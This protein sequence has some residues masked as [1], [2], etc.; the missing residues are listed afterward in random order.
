MSEFEFSIPVIV[1]GGGACGAVAAL[2]AH[3]AGAQVIVIERDA[4]PMGTSA[5]SQGVFC[6]A[7]TRFQKEAGVEDSA[8]IF[9][10]DIMEKSRGLAD[11]AI[12]R[13]IAEE[14]APT[15]EW[16][17]DRHDFPWKLNSQFRA[18]YGNSRDR[19][20]G[21]EGHAGED[22]VQWFHRRLG[23][24]GIDVLCETRLIDVVPGEDGGIAGVKLQGGDG[25]ITTIGCRALVMACGGFGANR[26]MTDRYMPETRGFRYNG[27]EGS[28]GDAICIGEK[29]GAALADMGSF[30][31]Y[32]MLAEPGGISVP[33][34]VLIEG[35]L[36]VNASGLRFVDESLDI[37]GMVLPLS[38]QPD[39]LGWVIFD[40][41]IYDLCRHIPELQDLEKLGVV[42]QAASLAQLA[43]MT[44]LPGEALRCALD[45]VSQARK[46][47][48]VDRLGRNWKDSHVPASPFRFVKVTG[49]LYHTQGG[50]Q[51]DGRARVVKAD[52]T[53]F[54]NLFAGGG[55]ARAV[56]GPSSWGYLPA[57]GLTTAIVLGQV[58]GR[59]AGRIAAG[60]A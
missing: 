48:G 6:A 31:G 22:M 35:G 8:D 9:F 43:D 12:A 19:I 46:S 38:S 13:L 28:E 34:N 37:A 56:S 36:I 27:H 45:E 24:L 21:W 18:S 11:P 57:M 52:G 53:A 51:I 42:R 32:A 15:L 60:P 5:M 14:S 3:D 40:Q 2:A 16:L 23:D 25:G 20:H 39:G 29:H 59:E 54:P 10:K 33:P 58:A 7:G 17:C 41:P 47:G 4:H 26:E 30:Q 55:S 1:A 50:L 49:A 44:G